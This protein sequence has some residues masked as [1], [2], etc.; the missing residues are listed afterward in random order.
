MKI[1]IFNLHK[2]LLNI[3]FGIIV[4]FQLT[5]LKITF[6]LNL[7]SRVVNI[8]FTLFLFIFQFY[9]ISQTKL[10]KNLF[11]FY[12]LPGVLIVFGYLIS[13]IK[14]SFTSLDAIN[15]ISQIMPWMTFLIIPYFFQK[16]IFKVIDYWEI[17]SKFIFYTTIFSLI[18]YFLT[19][20][21][22]ITLKSVETPFGIFLI[23]KITIFHQLSDGEPHY[24]FYSCFIE[25][26]S[27]AMYLLPLIC[28]AFFNKK[29]L[30][31]LV[32]LTALY[33]TFSLGGIIS[34]V[35]LAILILFKYKGIKKY[36]IVFAVLLSSIFYFSLFFNN[37]NDSYEQKGKS[38]SVREDNFINT[39]NNFSK[40]LFNYPFGIPLKIDTAENQKNEFY[41]GANFTPAIYLQFGGILAFFGYTFF[42][43]FSTILSLF[44]YLFKNKMSIEDLIITISLI[45]LFPFIFQR[46]T[47]MESSIFA[48]LFSPYIINYLYNNDKNKV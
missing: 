3:I 21:N 9:A 38:A 34:L 11:Y 22:Y 33:F 45:S 7:I 31:L 2:T 25:P 18:E 26:G 4:V 41:I 13:I 19:I 23:G 40:I 24:R 17:F 28:H 43:V 10:S 46:L 12:L 30:R 6:D 39:V 27:Y 20:N 15:Y 29:Y 48:I 14:S 5:T 16:N 36:I 44:I 8:I 32:F 42:L 37:F 35:I 1:N 47:M